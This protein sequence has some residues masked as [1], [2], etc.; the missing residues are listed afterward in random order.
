MTLPKTILV[1]TDFGTCSDCALAYAVDLAKALGAELVVMHAYEIP[2]IGF[3][4]GALI[5]TPELTSRVLEG[6]DIGLKKAAESHA[7]SGVPMRTL[8]KQGSTWRTITDTATEL[9]VGMIVMGT[10]GRHG[11][12]RALLGSVA[13]KVVRTST[14]PVLTVHTADA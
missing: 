7:S 8:V 5:A 1:P 10:H 3:P 12:P 6:V 13:E 4:D 14:C 2:V 9:G 11:L